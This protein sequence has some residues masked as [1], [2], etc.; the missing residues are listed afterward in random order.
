MILK[1]NFDRILNLICSFHLNPPSYSLVPIRLLCILAQMDQSRSSLVSG[2]YVQRLWIHCRLAYHAHTFLYI[3]DEV[4][5]F[6]GCL[7]NIFKNTEFHW[8]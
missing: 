7:I 4:N 6:P 8:C 1:M 3:S 5:T 2:E